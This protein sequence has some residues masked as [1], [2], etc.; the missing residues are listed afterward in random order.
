MI[1]KVQLSLF[2]TEKAR[3]VMIYNETRKYQ[4][5]GDAPAELVKLMH[6]EPKRYFYAKVKNGKFELGRRAPEQDW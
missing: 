1:V 4:Y 6:G 2:T 3:Q 5:E